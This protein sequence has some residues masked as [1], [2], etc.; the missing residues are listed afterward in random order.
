[1]PANSLGIKWGAERRLEFI[2][3]KLCWEGTVNRAQLVE[4]FGISMQQAS[5]DLAAYATRWPTNLIY[6]RSAK[7]YRAAPHFVS[8]QDHLGAKVYLDELAI[9][10][11]SS[12]KA[13]SFIGWEPPSEVL[14]YPSRPIRTPVLREILSAIR[15][16][17]EVEVTY[18]SMRRPDASV[19]WIAPHALA[20]DGARW[21]ARAWCSEREEFRDFVLSRIE[22]V[23]ATRP[24]TVDTLLDSDWHSSVDIILRPMT[25]LSDNQRVTVEAEYGMKNG[26][27][28][29]RSRRALVYYVLRQLHL[30]PVSGASVAD[31]PIKA[32]INAEIATLIEAG[33][34]TSG[35]VLTNHQGELC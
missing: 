13:P 4:F 10:K 35:G 29:L 26:Q 3:F 22:N 15:K 12:E 11:A 33:K 5:A 9:K 25:G 7:T 18:Q 28:L 21:H 23:R 30:I 32:E 31:Q 19:R 2:D 20:N 16:R 34:K 14:T 6:D 27:L 8:S 1:M 17:Q 24:V